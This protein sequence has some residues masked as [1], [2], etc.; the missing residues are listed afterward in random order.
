MMVGIT[1]D[2]GPALTEL[3]ILACKLHALSNQIQSL[4]FA[5]ERGWLPDEEVQALREL[6]K[7]HEQLRSLADR[8]WNDLETENLEDFQRHLLCMID[9][10]KTILGKITDG[11]PAVAT[12]DPNPDYY[13][14][15][16]ESLMKNC[17]NFL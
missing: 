11:T 3:Y 9:E 16:L 7:E 5:D 8:L 10:L 15:L 14:S 13:V 1:M 4:A 2:F 6:E 17:T 12:T